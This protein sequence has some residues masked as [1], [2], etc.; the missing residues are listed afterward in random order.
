MGLGLAPEPLTPITRGLPEHVFDQ[1]S[2]RAGPPPLTTSAL[3]A[4]PGRHGVQAPADLG[5]GLLVTQQV[6][7]GGFWPLVKKCFSG[8]SHG[9][10]GCHGYHPW[11]SGALLL[12][13]GLNSWPPRLSKSAGSCPWSKSAGV[14]GLLLLTTFMPI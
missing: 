6:R 8:G 2:K 13:L 7:K 3:R 5:V 12:G 4:H 11:A 9:Y 14:G 10:Q 1:W